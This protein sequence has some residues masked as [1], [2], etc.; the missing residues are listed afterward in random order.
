MRGGERGGEAGHGRGSLPA[1]AAVAV[2][3]SLGSGACVS[4][5][6]VGSVFVNVRA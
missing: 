3:G 4:P 2:P 5:Q 6:H 1:D